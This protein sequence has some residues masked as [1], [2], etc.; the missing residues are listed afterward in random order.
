MYLSLFQFGHDFAQFTQ[1][2]GHRKGTFIHRHL[3]EHHIQFT[4]HLVAYIKID[5]PASVP[6]D[7]TENGVRPQSKQGRGPT[8][9]K[10]P[11]TFAAK[12]FHE[13]VCNS[14]VE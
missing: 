11:Q 14:C 13:A 1:L 12:Y 8:F 6:E 10:A 3:P 2:Y 5:L 4:L 9:V 7:Q